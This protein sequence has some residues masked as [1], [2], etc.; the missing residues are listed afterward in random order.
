MKRILLV[1]LIGL[2]TTN[3]FSLSSSKI[4]QNARFLSDRMA[5][6]LDLTPMQYE[7]C[8]EIN[9]DFIYNI[10]HLMNDVVFGYIDAIDTYYDYLDMRNED[11]RY[12]LNAPQYVKFR[13]SEYFYNPVYSTGSTW[14]FRIYTIYSNRSF[15]YFDSP[16]IYKTYVGGHSHKYYND[17]YYRDRINHGPLGISPRVTLP[18]RRSAAFGDR[19]KADFGVNVRERNEP[20]RYNNYNNENQR[21]RTRD[22]R[23]RDN[24]G[25]RYSPSINSPAAPQYTPPQQPIPASPAPAPAPAQQPAPTPHHGQPAPAAQPTQPAPAP[26]PVQPAQPAVQQPATTQPAP[27]APQPFQRNNSTAPATSTNNNN[28]STTQTNTQSGSTTP[29]NVNQGRR[30]QTNVNRQGSDNSGSTRSSSSRRR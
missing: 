30:N 5:Y 3:A 17:G 14:N 10:N 19:R 1:M 28:Q 11:L 7:Y 21:N 23:Y 29:A 24:S 26:Q 8:Y 20:I 2:F 22:D 25:N 12:V 9:Y 13:A 4:R 27:P 18:D 6:E 15:Y 16:S